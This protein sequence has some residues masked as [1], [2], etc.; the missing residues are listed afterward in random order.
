MHAPTSI[1]GGHK[2]TSSEIQTT[3]TNLRQQFAMFALNMTWQLAVAVLVPVIGGAELD[4]A[5]RTSVYVFVGL[6]IA[7]IGSIAVMWRTMR[8]AN[9]LPVPKVT[10]AQKQAI[11]KS[12][13]EED[14][15]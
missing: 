5:M 10:A 13:E 1:K 7:V 2:P 12:Y 14:E 15:A 6:G 8:A 11:K 3:T 9:R 4:K